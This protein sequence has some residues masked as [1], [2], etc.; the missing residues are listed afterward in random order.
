MPTPVSH[1]GQ[2]DTESARLAKISNN[3][4]AL[5]ERISF[6]GYT[7]GVIINTGPG[8]RCS[9][10]QIW[11][12]MNENI[13]G[14]VNYLEGSAGVRPGPGISSWAQ[15]QALPTVGYIGTNSTILWVEEATGLLKATQLRV[16]TDATDTASGIARPDDYSASNQRV[17][18]QAN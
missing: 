15:L 4:V 13:V 11:S 16:G 6:G 3:L 10:V 7:T 2:W 17:W 12:A 9:D 1:V 8:C 18:Y 14:F 5:F